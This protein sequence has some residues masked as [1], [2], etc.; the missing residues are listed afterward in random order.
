MDASDIYTGDVDPDPGGPDGRVYTVL[1]DPGSVGPGTGIKE[2]E[3][4]VS[5][6]PSGHGLSI[7]NSA[8]SITLAFGVKKKLGTTAEAQARF[9]VKIGTTTLGTYTV[10]GTTDTTESLPSGEGRFLTVEPEQVAGEPV[11][12]SVAYV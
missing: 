6:L 2:F 1:N 11:V 10:S 12:F 7:P 9:V 3:P 8:T 5:V 4:G